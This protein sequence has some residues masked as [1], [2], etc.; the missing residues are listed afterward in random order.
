MHTIGR[1]FL[2]NKNNGLL[3][4]SLWEVAGVSH[5]IW[6]PGEPPASGQ[7]T[8][9]SAEALKGSEAV[10]DRTGGC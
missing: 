3:S 5:M 2:L 6:N 1:M 7:R 4:Y 8:A 9:A 10:S